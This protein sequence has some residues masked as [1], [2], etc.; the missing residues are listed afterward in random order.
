MMLVKLNRDVKA[1][2]NAKWLFLAIDIE[3]LC[4]LFTEKC[5]NNAFE[6]SNTFDGWFSD[7]LFFTFVLLNASSTCHQR[8]FR[9]KDL[10]VTYGIATVP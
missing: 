3:I 1:A 4:N 6:N 10:S 7:F 8:S 9:F 5:E 2:F